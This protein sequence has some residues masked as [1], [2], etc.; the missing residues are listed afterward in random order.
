MSTRAASRERLGPIAR[1]GQ[2]IQRSEQQDDIGGLVRQ[3]QVSR[4]AHPA[5]RERPPG[6]EAP[7]LCF[8]HQ[9]GRRVDQVN[10]I[11]RLGQPECIRAGRPA[12][13]HDESRRW[14]R[15]S[16]N[17]LPGTRLLQLEWALL[18]PSFFGRSLVEVCDVPVDGVG[19][20]V[21][22]W[23]Q[24]LACGMQAHPA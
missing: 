5:G 24:L 3:V 23:V 9:P 8:R 12:D 4:V 18:E 7:P 10:G 1:V 20:W 21:G 19:R 17:Q 14:R 22:H 15:E 11:P 2:V 16:L 13:V 6:R